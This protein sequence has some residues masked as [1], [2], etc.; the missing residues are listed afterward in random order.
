VNVP[1]KAY[2]KSIERHG[3]GPT[4][5]ENGDPWLE[6]KKLGTNQSHRRRG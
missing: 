4:D 3:M 2:I 6:M 1:I 5:E